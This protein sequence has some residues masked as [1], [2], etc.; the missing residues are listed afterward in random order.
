M[1]DKI[2]FVLE[3]LFSNGAKSIPAVLFDP[4]PQ[5]SKD[6]SNKYDVTRYLN[7]AFLIE[8]A[9]KNHPYYSEA[10]ASLKQYEDQEE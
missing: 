3:K 7:A 5:F 4:V 10:M 9:G 1:N 8:L 2:N 6:I